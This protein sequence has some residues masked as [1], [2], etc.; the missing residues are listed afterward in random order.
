MVCLS[1]SGE[2]EK[3]E[4]AAVADED[5]VA[6]DGVSAASSDDKE[7]D[8]G[9]PV[10]PLYWLRVHGDETSNAGADKDS[11]VRPL[12]TACRVLLLV[13]ARSCR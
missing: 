11:E 3:K 9:E 4:A 7:K 10:S 1:Q 8:K 6:L 5:A 13:A 2:G 12:P